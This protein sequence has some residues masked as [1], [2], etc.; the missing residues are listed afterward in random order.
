MSPADI[1]VIAVILVVVAFA[2]RSIYKEKKN[3]GCSGNCSGCNCN[4]DSQDKTTP[5]K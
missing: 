3:G 2:I 5:H 1:V 4:C